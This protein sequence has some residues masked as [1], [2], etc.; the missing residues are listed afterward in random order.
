MQ[1]AAQA[2]FMP[3]GPPREGVTEVVDTFGQYEAEYAAI[4]KGA[5]FMDTPW[6]GA[7]EVRGADR[8]D[9]LHKMLTHDTLSLKPGQGRRAFLLGRTGRIIAE[10]VVLEDRSI[11]W[12]VPRQPHV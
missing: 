10:L 11:A 3:F 5:A 1:E 8:L 12:L 4:R 6:R 9:F 7:I 2:T